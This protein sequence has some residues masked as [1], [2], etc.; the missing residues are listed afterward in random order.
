LYAL[1]ADFISQWPQPAQNHKSFLMAFSSTIGTQFQHALA[2][3]GILDWI[4]NAI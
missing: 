3:Y 1:I 4:G 2:G